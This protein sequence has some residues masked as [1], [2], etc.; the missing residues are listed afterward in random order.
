MVKSFEEPQELHNQEAECEDG[1]VGCL[2]IHE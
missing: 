2:W 1:A